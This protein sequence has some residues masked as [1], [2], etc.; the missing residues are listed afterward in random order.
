MRMKMTRVGLEPTTSRFVLYNATTAQPGLQ[1]TKA[2]HS[3]KLLQHHSPNAETNLSGLFDT[4]L[5]LPKGDDLSRLSQII[6]IDFPNPAS[7]QVNI[8]SKLSS[9]AKKSYLYL[10]TQRSSRQLN[11]RIVYF[12]LW[13]RGCHVFPCSSWHCLVKFVC[14]CKI[15]F[16]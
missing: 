4:T 3:H 16:E 5:D 8:Y 6:S 2:I 7:L 14:F 11:F 15:L 10:K 13:L 12:V 1:E 9:T